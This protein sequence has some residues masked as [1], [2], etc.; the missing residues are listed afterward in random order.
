MIGDSLTSKEIE[1]EINS[2]K[3]NFENLKKLIFNAFNIENNDSLSIENIND[4]EEKKIIIWLNRCRSNPNPIVHSLFLKREEVKIPFFSQSLSSKVNLLSQYH[5]PICKAENQ[6][7]IEIIPIRISAISK[8]AMAK[9]P[10]YRI[11]FEK[12]ISSKFKKRTIDFKKGEKLCILVVFILGKQNRNKDL[13]N[14]SKAIMDALEGKLF[15]NDMDIEHLNLLKIR[16]D[17][18]EDYVTINIRRTDLNKHRDVL[19]KKM[20]HGWAGAEFLNLEEFL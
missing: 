3:P 19:F 11:A 10:K 17:G 7:P 1:K 20:A 8:Q 2:D 5:C 6:F 9:K 12:A 15:E 16:H 4:E 13:D 14:M 18:D